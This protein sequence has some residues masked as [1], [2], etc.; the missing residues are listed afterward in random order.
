MPDF[1]TSVPC[2][3]CKRGTLIVTETHI[4]CSHCG[5]K[6]KLPVIPREITINHKTELQIGDSSEMIE[7][8]IQ[9]NTFE[10][11]YGDKFC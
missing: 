5:A 6:F 8:P 3:I 9:V 7:T 1:P 4:Y 2:R 10:L 11:V